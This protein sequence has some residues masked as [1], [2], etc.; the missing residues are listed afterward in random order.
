MGGKTVDTTS[1]NNPNPTVMAAY[2]QLLSRAKSAADT[3][4]KPYTGQL[5]ADFTPDQMQAFKSIGQLQGLQT[6]F[7]TAATKAASGVTGINPSTY[8]PV[9]NINP[10]TWAAGSGINPSTWAATAGIDP[11]TWAAGAGLNPSSYGPVGNINPSSFGPISTGTINK[12]T[13]SLMNPY[14]KNVVDATQANINQSDA[15]QQQQILGQAASQGAF[16]GSR[17]A[18]AQSQLARQQDLAGQQTIANLMSQGY[19]QAQASAMANEQF[20]K[21]LGFAGQQTN[22][23]NQQFNKQLGLSGAEANLQN[24]QFYKQLGLTGQQLNQQNQQFY[25]QLGLSGQQTNLQNQQFYKQLGLTGQQL[26]QQNQQFNKQLG[27]SGQQLTQQDLL[28]KA[29]LLSGLGSQTLQGGL[30]GASAQLQAGSL[31]Q[32]LNQQK[33]NNQYSIWQQGQQYP[34]QTTGWLGNLV[35]GL[36]GAMGGTTT[37]TVPNGNLLSQLGGLGLGIGALSSGAGSAA[38]LLGFKRGGRA[39]YDDGGDVGGVGGG[40]GDG[41]DQDHDLGGYGGFSG[42][43]GGGGV[44]VGIGAGAGT[45]GGG[46]LGAG[47]FG[48]GIG[49]SGGSPGGAA[50]VGGG[51]PAGAGGSDQTGGQPAG[52]G[53]Q[54]PGGG[55]SA[56]G[57]SA[58]GLGG[59][60][61]A[62]GIGGPSAP[63]TGGVDM[64]G[65]SGFAPGQVTGDYAS[66]AGGED[67]APAAT[68]SG[69]VW[70][71][72]DAINNAKNDFSSTYPAL[73]NFNP[74]PQGISG[75][76]GT[77]NYESGATPGSLNPNAVN[78]IGAIGLSQ[79][80]GTRKQGLLSSLGLSGEANADLGSNPMSSSYDPS[81][82]DLTGTKDKQIAYSLNEMAT[83]PMYAKSFN[84]MQDPNATLNQ[85][86]ATLGNNFERPGVI[87]S[88]ALRGMPVGYAGRMADAGAWS[89]AA[90]IG[91]MPGAPSVQSDPLTGAQVFG[92]QQTQ[93]QTVSVPGNALSWTAG[94]ASSMPTAPEVMPGGMAP[95]LQYAGASN[96]LPG[97]GD[98]FGN[99]KEWSPSQ[100]TQNTFPNMPSGLGYG[101]YSGLPSN[102]PNT[103]GTPS[104]N[105]NNPA[106]GGIGSFNPGTGF[107]QVTPDFS[108]YGQPSGPEAF[109]SPRMLGEPSPGP[110]TSMEAPPGSTMVDIGPQMRALTLSALGGFGKG[111]GAAGG[112]DAAPGP[113]AGAAPMM[114]APAIAGGPPSW[115]GGLSMP[116]GP[117]GAPAAPSALAPASTPPAWTGGLSVP[118]APAAPSPTVATPNPDDL[119]GAPPLELSSGL[120]V[121]TPKTLAA[122]SEWMARHGGTYTGAS[123]PGGSNS[124][125]PGGS[126]FTQSDQPQKSDDSDKKQTDNSQSWKLPPLKL[127]KYPLD[128]SSYTV[129]QMLA[130]Y[131]AALAGRKHGGRVH[132]DTGGI[133][134]P[135]MSATSGIPYSGPGASRTSGTVPLAA[136]RGLGFPK[137]PSY[138]GI[139]PA[140]AAE[141][142]L[143]QYSDGKRIGLFAHG[144]AVRRYADG[145]SDDSYSPPTDNST[146]DYSVSSAGTPD[147]SSAPDSSAAPMSISPPGFGVS[148]MPSAAPPSPP[149]PAPAGISSGAAPSFATRPMT[150]QDRNMMLLHIAA[151]M[152]A[153][154]SPNALQGI[155]EGLQAGADSY[156]KSRTNARENA[157][158]QSEIGFRSGSLANSSRQID[159]E[160]NNLMNQLALRQKEIAAQSGLWAA[161]TENAQAEAKSRMASLRNV[162]PPML[163]PDGKIGEYITDLSSPTPT[164]VWYP[165]GS[166]SGT[167]A[168]GATPTGAASPPSAGSSAEAAATAPAPS[169]TPPA[170]SGIS[171]STASPAASGAPPTTAAPTPMPATAPPKPW[172]TPSGVTPPEG[173]T[174]LPTGYFPPNQMLFNASSVR[175]PNANKAVTDEAARQVAEMRESASA[176]YMANIRLAEMNH[177]IESLPKT[178]LL[179]EGS[180][181]EFRMQ[182]AKA[183]NTLSHV[184]NVPDFFSEDKIAPIEQL[185]KD[186]FN[187]GVELSRRAGSREPGFIITAAVGA[188]PSADNTYLGYKKIQSALVE[189]NQY[190]IDRA[191]FMNDYFSKFRNLDNAENAFN[192]LHPWQNYAARAIENGSIPP[193]PDSVPK[194]SSYSMSRKMWVDPSGLK[195]TP[196]GNKI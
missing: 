113:T 147:M 79:D 11:S 39:H 101:D 137:A 33:L 131:K 181:S 74:T 196:N 194:D 110:L 111:A 66:W 15:E 108:S 103:L 85:V 116:G 91:G 115:A 146:D 6:P 122:V 48:L 35:E 166:A 23:Q 58:L 57:A 7:I 90:G 162:S 89:A 99:I 123:G 193:R 68:I 106:F 16:G 178:G 188:N 157:N 124:Q 8:S 163:G 75:L 186:T 154:R 187:L 49:G 10:S 22:Q 20:N 179:S 140:N 169:G 164:P 182:A 72:I 19:S 133:T 109:A 152:M 105:D 165:L 153:S 138:N 171:P 21:Q 28:S 92:Q 144:G 60:G 27:I 97:N 9:S 136:S 142:F 80:L 132:Y 51:S 55:V 177:N 173:D 30:E 47:G 17:S 62:G 98:P 82:G 61:L 191:N 127:V 175:D 112:Y 150:P 114:G 120:D 189:T 183:A 42:D 26:N 36:G 94:P 139:D 65:P 100:P 167:P 121:N 69:K 185:K 25:K 86:V 192:Q 172:S 31:E 125:I 70:G 34:F 43:P 96:N 141:Q 168:A 129:P 40:V 149:T 54:Q 64:S 155:G 95:A 93:Q 53:A 176:S 148:G 56:L 161:Q 45:I 59:L 29:G 5:T 44:G 119:P 46:G 3:G 50:T 174:T 81:A 63:A 14:I 158:T 1:T 12:D 37:G 128:K 160:A 130:L 184:F 195:Y 24:Q 118:G 32:A 104:V 77:M 88:G 159:N 73:A 107:N 4:Y 84:A 52:A 71:P 18:V 143:K 151:G 135:Y 13:Q 156:D 78:G 102:R 126:V 117:M 83:N 38:S 87:Q 170:P 145:G 190:V 180:G 2:Q 134:T 41:S 76:L 67:F